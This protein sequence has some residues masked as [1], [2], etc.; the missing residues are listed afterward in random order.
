MQHNPRLLSVHYFDGAL[1]GCDF[2]QP[3]QHSDLSGSVVVHSDSE[4]GS[5]DRRYRC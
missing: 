1:L 2:H 3:F 5:S 4:L